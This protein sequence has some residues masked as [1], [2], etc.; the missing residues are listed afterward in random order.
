MATP[1]R[2]AL[3][4]TKAWVGGSWRGALS[5][6]TFPVYNPAKGEL[7]AE[8]LQMMLETIVLSNECV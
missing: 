7:I 1:G 4:R 8:V 6:A 2:L 3:L 5:E